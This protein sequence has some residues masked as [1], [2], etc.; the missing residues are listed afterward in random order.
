MQAYRFKHVRNHHRYNNDPKGNDGMTKDLSS[1]FRDGVDGDHASPLRYAL[2]GALSTISETVRAQL[3]VTRLWN[4][5]AQEPELLA[6]AAPSLLKRA[7]ELRQ[8]RLDRMAHFVGL[9]IFASMSWTWFLFCYVPT[10]YAAFVLVNVQNYYEHYG[11]SP[12]ARAA[13]SVSH[14]GRLYNLLTFNDGY[15]QEHHLCPGAHWSEMPLVRERFKEALNSGDRIISPIPAI[16]GF[17]HRDRALL[18]R[19]PAACPHS[20]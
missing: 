10:L 9:L 1:T 5:G 15:H 14:Y 20:R 8:I 7:S 18:H 4:V 19:R 6:L 13:N 11:A 2:V 12:G 16:L 3:S 17:L